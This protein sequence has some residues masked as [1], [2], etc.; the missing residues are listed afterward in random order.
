MLLGKQRWIGGIA[1][2]SGRIV[3]LPVLPWFQNDT[4]AA[5]HRRLVSAS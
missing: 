1:A 2:D 3:E 5:S 4:L